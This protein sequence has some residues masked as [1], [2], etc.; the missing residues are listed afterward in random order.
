[1]ANQVSRNTGGRYRKTDETAGQND[2]AAV[3]PIEAGNHRVVDVDMETP[4]HAGVA[5]EL[6]V[7]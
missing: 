5:F 3:W 6:A 2:L 7:S 4:Q 1:M